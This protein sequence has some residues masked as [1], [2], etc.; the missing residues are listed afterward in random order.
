MTI[1]DT[2]LTQLQYAKELTA[3]I[4]NVTV[5]DQTEEY[6][7]LYWCGRQALDTTDMFCESLYS[8]GVITQKQRQLYAKI[9]MQAEEELKL[10]R[11][12]FDI[13]RGDCFDLP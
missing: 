2:I 11:A 5:Y 1:H 8:Q 9:R 7:G 10:Q 3:E 6:I 12:R 4:K 13:Y